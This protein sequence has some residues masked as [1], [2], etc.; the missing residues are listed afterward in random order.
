MTRWRLAAAAS[1]VAM[2]S[3]PVLTAHAD[4]RVGVTGAVNPAAAGTPPGGASRQLTVGSE[5]IFR[6]RVVTTEQGQAQILFLDQS[7]LLIGPDSTVVID[8]FVYDPTTKKGNMAA[9]LTQGSFRYIGGKLSKQGNATLKTPVATLGIRGSDVTVDYDPT[10]RVM[11]VV[12]THGSALLST[13]SDSVNLRGGFGVTVSGFDA[14][15]TQPS[16]LSAA[17]IAA[18]NRAFEGLSGRSAGAGRPPTDRDVDRSGISK[19]V[20]AKSPPS[21]DSGGAAG[22]GTLVPFA[23]GNNDTPQRFEPAP[24]TSEPPP[25]SRTDRRLSGYAAGLSV[26][27]FLSNDTSAVMNRAPGE[28]TIHTIPETTGSG[29]VTATFFYQPAPTDPHTTMD[30]SVEIEL[31]PPATGGAVASSRFVNDQVFTASQ[32]AERIAAKATLNGDPVKVSATLVSIPMTTPVGALT[33][34]AAAGPPCECQFMT[35]GTWS[36]QLQSTPSNTVLHRVP[37][38][39]WVAGELPDLEDRPVQGIA[40]FRGTA[41]GRVSDNGLSRTASGQ[42][43]N[44][45][46]FAARSGR[47]DFRKFDGNKSFGGTVTAPG[48]WR[49]YSGTLAG[50]NLTGTANGAFYGTRDA[51]NRVQ[52]P[53]ETGGNFAVRG[54]GYTAG[55]VFMGR[56]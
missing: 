31:G 19:T 32:R 33:G 2:T 26:P 48:D 34:D 7:S 51:A 45:F 41:I 44:R 15:L 30:P 36:A 23:P 49:T 11:N 50:S 14:R 35:W 25:I 18:A 3:L 6:E 37:T 39:F 16:A 55:G 24:T 27:A 53:K 1:A 28:V 29:R 22:P 21:S 12:T 42:F 52:L 8:E 56:R 40:T 43:I 20:A 10:R 5:I 13:A 46:D 4:T 17:Q 54:N 38:G 47:L 9:T